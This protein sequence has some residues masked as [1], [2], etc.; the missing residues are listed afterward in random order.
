LG[1]VDLCN[2]IC[3][4]DAESDRG[5]RAPLR[6]TNITLDFL[7]CWGFK[8]EKLSVS[9]AVIEEGNHRCGALD[10]M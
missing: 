1:G 10:G 4:V 5:E 3:R 6:E 2:D 8:E 7:G 9:K